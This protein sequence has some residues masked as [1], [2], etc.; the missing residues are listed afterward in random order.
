MEH[1]AIQTSQNIA[2]EQTI[3]SVGERIVA[4]IIDYAFIFSYTLFISAFAGT[5][6]KSVIYFIFLFCPLIFYHVVS[7][8]A[9][10]GQS[11]GKKIMKLK[12][13]KID[14]TDASFSSYFIRW[15]FRL[16]D[17]W[18]FFGAVSCITV[19][20]NKKGQR[21]G[22]IAAN[23]TVIKLKDRNLKETL[24][25]K[26]PE[27]YTMVFPQVAKLNDADIYTSREVL[28]FLKESFFSK[29]SV[30]MALKAKTALESKMEVS[31]DLIP[32]KFLQ[33]IISDYNYVH[34]R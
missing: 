21:L 32:E 33:A 28:D 17:I 20:L 15:I 30:D 22:D 11:W 27:N 29:D 12:V 8:V 9:M 23:T 2:I 5:A 3:A 7:E 18:V 19:I 6:G 24:F 1:I 26:I 31:S 16:V 34:S 25:T 13:V 14:G 10:D 4:S